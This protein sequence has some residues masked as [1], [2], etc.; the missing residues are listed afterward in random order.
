MPDPSV[1]RFRRVVETAYSYLEARRNE[2]NDLNVFPVA[3]G[4]TGDNM[5]LT[6]RAVLAELDRIEAEAGRRPTAASSSTP[7][8]ERR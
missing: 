8:P 1:E 2:V 5:A 6:M 3:D 7:S 4:D